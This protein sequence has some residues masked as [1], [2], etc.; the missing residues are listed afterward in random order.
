MKVKKCQWRG[1]NLGRQGYRNHLPAFTGNYIF[2]IE[3]TEGNVVFKNDSFE[4]KTRNKNNEV[5]NSNIEKK[6]LQYLN[7]YYPSGMGSSGENVEIK[8][9]AE[10]TYWVTFNNGSGT[11][12]EIYWLLDKNSLIPMYEF[13]FGGMN[14]ESELS[15]TFKNIKDNATA[16]GTV[17]GVDSE[18]QI[19]LLKEKF[20]E[21]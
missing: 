2:Y 5:S 13:E 6:Y 20:I 11:Q 10:K 12:Q 15:Y 4:V 3:D 1:K 21:K 9:I 7:D 17:Y 14:W 8:R 16:S 18:S 19:N